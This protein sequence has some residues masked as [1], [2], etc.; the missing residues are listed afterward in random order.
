MKSTKEK[1]ILM[2]REKPEESIEEKKLRERLEKKYRLK[3]QYEEN[4]KV[5]SITGQIKVFIDEGSLIEKG[6]VGYYDINKKK[7]YFPE[8]EEFLEYFIEK[9][10]NNKE[11]YD[12][13][14]EQGFTEIMI[15]PFGMSLKEMA[16]LVGK[17]LIK[18]HKQAGLINTNGDKLDLNEENPVYMNDELKAEPDKTG[19]LV[20]YPK[21]YDKKNHE[22]KTKSEILEEQGEEVFAGYEAVLMQNLTEIPAKGDEKEIGGRQQIE[23]GKS[24]KKYLEM[25]ETEEQYKGESGMT[26]ETFISKF[27]KELIIKGVVICDIARAGKASINIAGYNKSSDFVCFGY[28]NRNNS[29]LNL[30]S[31][32]TNNSNENNGGWVVMRI[33]IFYNDLIQPPSIFPISNNR[34]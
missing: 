32:N 12:K 13:K 11:F 18:K 22:G 34:A 4:K 27:L 17:A 24:A 7:R 21:R 5:M 16:E 15:V 8:Y 28:W 30:N 6:K 31:N 2:P 23:A 26:M 14:Y 33:Y 20:N 29:Q 1:F 3:E 10:K 19:D 9:Y 25:L